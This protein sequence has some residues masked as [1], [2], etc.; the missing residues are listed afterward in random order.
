MT[1]IASGLPKGDGNGLNALARALIDSPQDIHVVVAL[2][3]CKKT[4]TDNDTGEVEPTARIRR[5]APA[6]A[7]AAAQRS[8]E[9]ERDA[10]RCHPFE[11]ERAAWLVRVDEGEGVRL[12]VTNRE[13]PVGPRS[14]TVTRVKRPEQR[15]IVQPPRLLLAERAE[16]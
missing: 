7:Q 6:G 8:R 10:D 4:T 9:V 13:R 12:A 1:K 11:R 5:I 14:L 2:I 15:V 3:D 16:R